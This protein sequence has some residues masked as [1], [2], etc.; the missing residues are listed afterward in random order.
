[1]A[2]NRFV[3]RD[4]F[5]KIFFRKFIEADVSAGGFQAEFIQKFFQAF[6][7]VSVGAEVAGKLHALKAHV[8]KFF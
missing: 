4:G 8:G 2:I 7:V 1:M 3:E 6:G 5:I